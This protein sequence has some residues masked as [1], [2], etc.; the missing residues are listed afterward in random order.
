MKFT[1][2][3]AFTDR[4]FG[5]NPAGIVLLDEDA[6]FPEDPLCIQTAAELRYSETVFIKKLET[7]DGVDGSFHFRYFTPTEEVDLCGHATIAAFHVLNCS[8][9]IPHDG[10]YSIQTKAGDLAVNVKDGFVIMEMGAPEHLKTFTTDF[11]IRELYQIMGVQSDS[12]IAA[13]GCCEYAR[14]FPA[15]IS[16]GLPDILLPV[17]SLKAL[18]EMQPDFAAL[19]GFSRK[20]KVTGVHAFTLEKI[21]GEKNVRAHVRNFAPAVGIN[22]E[23][24]TGTSNGAL[25]YYLYLNG[26]IGSDAESLFVQGESMGRPSQVYTHLKKTTN[27]KVVVK[28][29][30]TAVTLAA[31]D[32]FI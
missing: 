9:M 18:H 21:A 22:E 13:V 27:G 5:G 6:G 4:L 1:I 25:T 30:G 10:D 11:E 14:L 23:A 2:A 17:E 28:V 8:K 7:K 24:A 19:D 29:G 15:I 16:T 12:V 31:G 3:D 20:H 32:I 26:L